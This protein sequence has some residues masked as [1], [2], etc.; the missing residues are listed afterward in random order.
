MLSPAQLVFCLA[1]LENGFVAS[2]AYRAAHPK[3]SIQT[4]EVEASRYL[5]IP[6]VGAYL[7]ERFE[8]ILK[9]LQ[10]GGEEVVA[11]IAFVARDET[12]RTR[13]RLLAL[14]MLAEITGKARSLAGGIDELAAAIRADK[15]AHK[16]A[17]NA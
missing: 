3:A 15:E 7:A 11:R 16:D 4:S 2:Q 12:E 14:R 13:D 17:I 6:K 1:Y 8:T 5:R 9:P 10:M